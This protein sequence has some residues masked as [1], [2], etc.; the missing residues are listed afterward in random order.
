MDNSNSK[1]NKSNENIQDY[2]NDSSNE[3]MEEIH[4]MDSSEGNLETTEKI[5]LSNEGFKNK[6]IIDFKEMDFY[7]KDFNNYSLF[8]KKK[9]AEKLIIEY[10][11]ESS[12]YSIDDLLF[13]DQTNKKIQ[14]YYMKI[15]VNKLNSTENNEYKKILLEKIEKS[16]IIIDEKEYNENL[17][18]IKD[19]KIRK[20]L[21]YIK[22][23]QSLIDTFDFI[24]EHKDDKYSVQAQK[25]LKLFKIFKFNQCSEIGENNYYFYGLCLQLFD[26]IEEIYHNYNLYTDLIK[27]LIAFLKTENFDQLTDDK[28]YFFRYISQIIFN[29]RSL[30]SKAQ[31]DKIINH[32][33]GHPVSED[34]VIKSISKMDNFQQSNI[35]HFKLKYDKVSKSIKFKIKEK[36]RINRK[37]YSYST[38]NSYKISSFNKNILKLIEK[39]FDPNFES[40]LF[41][42]VIYNEDNQL[43]FYKNL[44]P[45]LDSAIIRILNSTSAKKF[46]HNYYG[47]KCNDLKYH[48]DRDDVQ[49]EIFRR[50]TFAPLFNIKDK[51]YTNPNDMTIIINSLP[52]KIDGIDTHSFNRQILHFGRV[53]VFCI[54]EILGHFFWR[55]YSYFTGGKIPFNTNEDLDANMGD[56][57]GFF[58][59]TKFL[60]LKNRLSI[61]LNKILCLLY[62]PLYLD[63]PIIK[64]DEFEFSEQILKTVINENENLFNFIVEKNEENNTFEKRET[65]ILLEDYLDILKPLYDKYIIVRCYRV[66]K[67]SIY[68]DNVYDF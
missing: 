1:K 51:G 63:Y 61:S 27:D 45:S 31:L 30:T 33:K 50:M 36:R 59:E 38:T 64:N 47:N 2:E 66:E 17:S 5:C 3:S 62:S 48:F 55:Y 8:E 18:K 15:A 21:V 14:N 4:S 22:Y 60:G 37:R 16:G 6:S 44:K 20:D 68:L 39:H 35:S 52:G 7:K 46:F 28:I 13:L 53:L 9:V 57:N 23:K 29:K 24:L 49:N 25:N 26:K 32:L 41:E 11:Q 34:E 67:N 19:E 58:V 12:K 54:H 42:N 43:E 56:E 65:K 40:N 10:S